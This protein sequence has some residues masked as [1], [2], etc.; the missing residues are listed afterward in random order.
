M[1]FSK[2]CKVEGLWVGLITRSEQL[3]ECGAAE[4]GREASTLWRHWLL[5][6]GAEKHCDDITSQQSTILTLQ[7]FCNCHPTCLQIQW[8]RKR[9]RR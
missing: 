4:C 2:H 5:R 8:T 6:H 1:Y 7:P 3:A 9:K